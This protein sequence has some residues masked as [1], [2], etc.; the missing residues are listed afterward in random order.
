MLN[1]NTNDLA[2]QSEVT[3]DAFMTTVC[4][5]IMGVAAI[6][7]YRTSKANKKEE[8]YVPKKRNEMKLPDQPNVHRFNMVGIALLLIWIISSIYT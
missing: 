1:L 2:S 7:Y 4:F 5:V 6:A 8:E 3:E